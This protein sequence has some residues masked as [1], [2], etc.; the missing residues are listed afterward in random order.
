MR[1]Q[2]RAKASMAKSWVGH[3]NKVFQKALDAYKAD[4]EKKVLGVMESVARNIFEDVSNTFYN[5]G[6][7]YMPYYT[8]NLRDSTGLGIYYNG[9]L[10]VLIPPRV[11]DKAQN[12][13]QIG[14]FYYDLWGFTFI[15]EALAEANSFNKGIWVVLYS[16]M[17][18]AKYVDENGVA[19]SKASLLYTVWNLP[20][21]NACGEDSKKAAAADD[22]H[23]Q[24]EW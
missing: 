17:P 7:D 1:K 14:H 10:S 13:W 19:D 12:Y 23:A 5:Q 9:A 22:G 3:N 21:R 11:A 6:D 2:S 16:T 8:G 4:I 18:Y 20:E 24:N 15:R